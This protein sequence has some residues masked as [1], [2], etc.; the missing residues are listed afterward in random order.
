MSGSK[1]RSTAIGS[2]GTKSLTFIPQS[3]A[4]SAGMSNRVLL[5]MFAMSLSASIKLLGPITELEEHQLTLRPK[6]L[7]A[8][9]QSSSLD[10]LWQPL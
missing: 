1:T 2:G 5:K 3:Q 10:S 6:V 7:H 4:S 9:A 8:L